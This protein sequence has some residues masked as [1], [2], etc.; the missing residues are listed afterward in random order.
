MSTTHRNPRTASL[1]S[2]QEA[3]APPP[4]VASA[5]IEPP[6]V[7]IEVRLYTF[8][9][10]PPRLQD[11]VSIAEWRSLGCQVQPILKWNDQLDTYLSVLDFFFWMVCVT[12]WVWD[13]WALVTGLND[14][15]RF[16]LNMASIVLL[17]IGF[18][19]VLNRVQKWQQRALETACRAAQD[20]TFGSLG[21]AL[22]GRYHGTDEYCRR[23]A[24]SVIYFN[25]LP[26][27]NGDGNN[28]YQTENAAAVFQRVE[29]P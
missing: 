4:H 5:T 14:T 15:W 17:L 10:V 21:W 2:E 8:E 20:A 23:R 9:T 1:L 3:A 26:A 25:P 7:Q 19:L 6:Y 13:P 22:E 12:T 11:T 28:W 16:A 24:H 29:L 27:C 18:Q